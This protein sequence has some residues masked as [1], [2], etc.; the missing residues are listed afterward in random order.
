MTPVSLLGTD[1]K[2]I[3]AVS[4]E[5]SNSIGHSYP[6]A[7]VR[8]CLT[9][10]FHGLIDTTDALTLER[11]E[12]SAVALSKQIALIHGISDSIASNG[13]L[14]AGLTSNLV[15]RF[16]RGVRLEQ[17]DDEIPALS[18]IGLDAQILEEVEVLKHVTYQSLIMS[19]RLKV[20]EYRG[21]EIVKSLFDVLTNRNDHGYRLL[22][23]D[24]QALYHEIDSEYQARVICD[25]I[26]GMTDRYA[27]EFLGRLTSENPETFFKPL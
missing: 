12:D 2:I 17:F 14:R 4:E 27:I 16:I 26:A 23:Q 6:P 5:V 9:K 11:I 1:D 19:P 25:F 20:A 18:K 21:R 8:S 24:V 13:Y 22:P 10:F 7:K 3:L 15:G